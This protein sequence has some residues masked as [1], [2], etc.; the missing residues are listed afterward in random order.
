MEARNEELSPTMGEEREVNP[1]EI[2]Q[3]S[4]LS[5]SWIPKSRNAHKTSPS[6]HSPSYFCPQHPGDGQKTGGEATTKGR[7]AGAGSSS[8]ERV[9]H[10]PEHPS[11]SRAAFPRLLPPPGAAFCTES[12][13]ESPAAAQVREG[14]PGFP[15]GISPR[16]GR[17]TGNSRR[18]IVEIQLGLWWL[19]AHP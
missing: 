2:P 15:A 5:C 3:M 4:H 13:S 10:S 12:S 17:D 1:A 19:G 18:G 6:E 11:A 14:T 16:A 7:I 9:P 8:L